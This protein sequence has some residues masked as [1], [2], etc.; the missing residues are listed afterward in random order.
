MK[1]TSM[2]SRMVS[3]INE[4]WPLNVVLRW[5]LEEEMPGGT[6]YAYV[7]GSCV[8]LIFLLQVL[9][10][11]WQL[12]YF[13]P[14]VDRGYDSLNYMRT[15]IPFGWLIHGLHYWG[16][17]AMII[18]V[19][20]HISQVY[21]WGA[22]K[23]PRQLTWLLGVGNLLLTLALGFSG[24]VLPWDERGY[25]E[26][27]VATSS[28]GTVPWLGTLGRSLLQGGP[29]L[30]QMTLSRFFFL[31]IAILPVTLVLF[32]V[33]HLV[34][35]RKSG[36]SGPWDE[37]RRKQTGFFWPDQVFKDAVVITFIFVVLVG[38]AAYVRT[39]FSGPLDILQTFY[40]PKPEWY[41]LF[42]YQTLKAFPGRLEPV[43]TMGIPLVVTLLLIFLP[44]YDPGPERNPRRRP[45]AM[46]CYVIFVAWVITMALVGYYSK[47]AAGAAATQDVAP[48]K[49]QPHSPSLTGPSPKNLES[50]K[51]GAQIVNGLA[52]TTCHRINGK[53]GAIGPELTGALLSG[54]SRE[55]LGVQIRNPKAHFPNSLMPAF[56]SLTDQQI[57]EVVDFL[58]SLAQGGKV[59]P[60]QVTKRPLPTAKT[61][62]I[63][64]E[65]R[66]T[67]TVTGPQGPPGP[68]SFVIG[69]V[70]LG[71]YLFKQ[72]CEQCHGSLGKDN[73]QNPGSK[74]HTVPPLNPIDP[75]L[76][77]K[78]AQIF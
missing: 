62:G 57:D 18:L 48:G 26:A 21:L 20:L 47:P 38:L 22:Y 71:E 13:V 3:W 29:I 69:N 28:A 64:P 41:F 6:S 67:R 15:E 76:L 24:P 66:S 8:L 19:G 25:W 70:E 52:C 42:F 61:E 9:T 10:G 14:T 58:F 2:V 59:S 37:T 39:P 56:S 12:L 72:N 30:G 73:V 46:V 65:T 44:F 31:H 54:K 43:G 51:R 55:W 50:V 77:N 16:A 36:I 11:V 5:S 4:R 63:P 35:F 27:E 32:V 23:N 7:F 75:T 17:T 40:V 45:T 49:I 53:G 74:D 34:A 1:G 78:N 33:F 68:A 60:A